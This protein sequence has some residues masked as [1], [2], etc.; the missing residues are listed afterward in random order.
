MGSHYIHKANSHPLSQPLPLLISIA[1]V[2][3]KDAAVGT[4]PFGMFRIPYRTF[5]PDSGIS[6]GF[7]RARQQ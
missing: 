5:G 2:D 7:L 3:T 1:P 4:T 6:L